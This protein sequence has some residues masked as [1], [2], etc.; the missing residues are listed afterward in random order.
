MQPS[1]FTEKSLSTIALSLCVVAIVGSL[2]LGRSTFNQMSVE[3]E[4]QILQ[5]DYTRAQ[6]LASLAEPIHG[7][8]DSTLLVRI[9]EMWEKEHNPSEDDYICIID[10]SGTLLLHTSAPQ[11]VGNY[12]G[13]N[14]L[15]SH[16]D[17][18]DTST[19]GKLVDS[20]NSYMGGYISSAG[21]KQI[22]AFSP[23]P[24]RGWA[25]GVHRSHEVVNDL[26]S[27]QL[28][29][30]FWSMLIISLGI[31]PI[32]FGLVFLAFL[33]IHR[34]QK[35]VEQ[36]LIASEHANRAITQTAADAIITIDSKGQVISWNEAAERIFGYPATQMVGSDLSAIIGEPNLD[37]HRQAVMNRS[38]SD[39]SQIIGKVVELSAQN[40]AGEEVPVELSLSSWKSGN[41]VR[42][43]SI[44]RDISERRQA[45]AQ[46]HDLE[47]QLRQAHKLE[48][49]GTMAGGIAHDFNN[50]LQAQFLYT[51]ILERQL[52]DDSKLKE[53][54]H[55]IVDAGKRA[56][57][58][59]RQILNF[60]QQSEVEYEVLPLQNIIVDSLELIKAALPSSIHLEQDIDLDAAPVNCDEQQIQQILLN[61]C[62]NARQAI[63]ED[64]GEIGVSFIELQTE[65][66]SDVAKNH[67]ASARGVELT[68]R[69]NG[70]G[71]SL[72]TQKKIF[73]PFFTT[74]EPDQGSGLGLAAT[75][76][77]VKDMGGE[78]DVVSNLGRGSSFKIW[79]PTV[80]E[81]DLQAVEEV[82]IKD[83]RIVQSV[84]FIDDEAAIRESAQA[85]LE[86]EGY[87]VVTEPSG[88][89]GLSRLAAG[90]ETFDVI[91]T[92]Y[93]M[94][95]MSGLEFSRKALELFPEVT[96]I[97]MSGNVDRNLLEG[98]KQ[99]G[100]K[101]VLQKP[102]TEETLL[103]HIQIDKVSLRRIEK[104]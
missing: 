43:T 67:F 21:Q 57:D 51:G 100:I 89:E 40:A 63:G 50:I 64:A 92:D 26:I 14:Y 61:L 55:F 95:G 54:L 56:R 72:E 93:T 88:K 37:M 25:I 52:A 46:R 33:R 87:R 83:T 41:D 44:V 5:H 2:A 62:N 15:V 60:S 101:T 16:E 80:D 10:S 75:Y 23:I 103:K 86:R 96:V 90:N 99:L 47:I 84:L 4:K 18:R 91:V 98:C 27:K 97:V 36:E 94:P 20:G 66:Y 77:I 6:L 45:E 1:R 12:A 65:N 48:A 71:M 32:S 42:Y 28:R 30:Q 38:E 29:S 13:R 70:C 34:G 104:S 68:V 31:I 102:W 8:S 35:L 7:L 39:Y 85:V 19:L 11:T 74:K 81:Q 53:Y 59:V 79:L 17:T 22:A 3:I 58:L 76:G 9:S 24:D 73:D 69:D 49:I 82:A 78:I